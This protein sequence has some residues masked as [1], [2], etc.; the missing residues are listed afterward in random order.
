MAH[1]QDYKYNSNPFTLAF[2][3]MSRMFNSNS[4][5]A[6]AIIVLG[7]LGAVWQG[8]SNLL[9]LI[10]GDTSTTSS[11]TTSSTALSSGEAV[12]VIILVAVIAVIVIGV[13]I[14]AAALQTYIMGMF[15][16]VALQSE[17]GKSVTF[18][19]AFHA[20][21]K[22]FWRMFW[23]QL[24]ADLK[25]FGW[26]LLLIVPGIIAA[27]RYALLSFVIMD[28]HN[29]KGVKA[30]HDRVKAVTKGR[31][32]EVMGLCVAAGIIPIV[33][34]VLQYAGGAAQYRQLAHTYDEKI[35][36]PKVHW[37]NYLAFML[38][39]GFLLVIVLIAIVVAAIIAA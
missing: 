27:L 26:T 6:I 31:L 16:Y 21:T 22:R 5:W 17:Q 37:L 7:F 10:P 29:T 30:A 20:T 32:I 34:G 13:I 3:A 4:G 1:N 23:A 8:I 11:S 9:S 35:E 2:D 38:F 36:R 12:A 24:L 19:E 39:G 33:T 18:S 28:D 14:V 15:A 25:I